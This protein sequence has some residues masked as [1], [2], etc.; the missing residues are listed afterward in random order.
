MFKKIAIVGV[1]LIGGS[2]GL[3]LSNKLTDVKITG[4]DLDKEN[5]RLALELGAVSE[6]TVSLEEGVRAAELVILAAPVAQSVI[7][8]ERMLPYLSAGTVITDVGSTKMEITARAAA[9]LPGDIYFVGGHPMAGSEISGV[10]GADSHLFENAYY[11][12]T[13]N[14][15]T[16]VAALSKVKY[17]VSLLGART[18]ELAPEEH[19]QSVAVIS[20]LPHLVA[21]TLVNTLAALPGWESILPLAAGGFKDTTRIAMSNAVMWRDIFLSNREKVLQVLADFNMQLALFKEAVEKSDDKKIMGLI[22]EAAKV[23]AAVPAKSKGYFPALYEIVVTIPD[24]PG[25]IADVTGYLGELDINISDI[26]ILRVREGH[27]GTI[28][29][30]FIDEFRQEAALRTLQ[31]QGFLVRKR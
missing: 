9:L 4:I 10:L 18:V 6:T 23:R 30:A 21:Y 5:L 11:L 28:R 2:I 15:D 19:D 3:S 16:D 24:R 25:M 27:E 17:M 8:L 26:E 22:Q 1:G 20:H 13:I 12:L 31:E 7:L 29:L 14:E